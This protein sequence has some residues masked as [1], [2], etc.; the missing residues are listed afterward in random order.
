MHAAQLGAC[1]RPSLFLTLT[2][3]AMT[4]ERI[5]R[6]AN[7]A[8]VRQALKFAAVGALATLVHYA[9]LVALVEFG[10]ASPVTATTIGYC[11]GILVSYTLNRRYT[12]GARSAP[13]ARTFLKFVLLYGVGALLN[14][15]IV[16]ILID[17]GLWYLLAQ[18]VATGL[19]LAWNFLGARFLVFR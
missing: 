8:I 5:S 13:I 2:A 3:I 9:I 12:F 1:A 4:L 10:R 15:V 7:Q 14:G 17:A 18:I 16:A 19:V 11:V 6:L